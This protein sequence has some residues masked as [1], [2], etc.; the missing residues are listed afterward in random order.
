MVFGSFMKK[1]IRSF[2]LWAPPVAQMGL[3]FYYS[4][5][6]AGSSALER[7]PL[8]AGLGHFVGYAILAF[9]FY[10]AFNGGSFRF[11]ARSA[12]YAF[13]AAALYG[14]FDEIHQLF[15]PGR[16]A[17]VVDIFIDAAGAACAVGLLYLWNLNKNVEE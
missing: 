13:G 8:P 12:L 4:S 3:I 1:F 7:F 17:T 11:A 16:Q 6:P 2:L 10:R 5:R 14:V 9:L 15:V